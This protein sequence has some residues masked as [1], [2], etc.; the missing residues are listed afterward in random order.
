MPTINT[1]TREQWLPQ[2][3]SALN[4]ELSAKRMDALC[5]A[6]EHHS[7]G[8]VHDHAMIQICWDADRLDLGRVGIKPI[9]K[10]M[11]QEAVKHIDEAYRCSREYQRKFENE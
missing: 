3:V 6:I 8:K 5:K 1:L 2:A 4:F 7:C 11:S 10:F 9:T